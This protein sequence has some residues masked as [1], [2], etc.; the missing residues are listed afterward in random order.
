M[1]GW[2]GDRYRNRSIEKIGPNKPSWPLEISE[3]KN[4]KYNNKYLKLTWQPPTKKSLVPSTESRGFT[5][6][7]PSFGATASQLMLTRWAGC[8]ETGCPDGGVTSSG[9]VASSV[10][11]VFA[12]KKLGINKFRIFF[13]YKNPFLGEKIIFSLQFCCCVF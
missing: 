3:L 8:Q 4:E 13:I 6:A 9:R 2:V 7:P 1:Q 10:F 12:K 11:S 5:K